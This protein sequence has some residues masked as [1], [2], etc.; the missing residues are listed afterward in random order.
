MVTRTNI[1][2]QQVLSQPFESLGHRVLYQPCCQIGPYDGSPGESIS[3]WPLKLP[4]VDWNQYSVVVIQCYDFLTI[5]QNTCIE[6]QVIEQYYKEKSCQV[7][8][9]HWERDLEKYYSG[10]L[11]LV[12][13][14]CH[15]LQ[16]ISDIVSN[17][18][19]W[20]SRLDYKKSRAWQ[21]LNGRTVSHREKTKNLLCELNNGV[22]SYGNDLALPQWS[23]KTYQGTDNFENWLRLFDV[24]HASAINVVTETIYENATGII[25]EKTLLAF[26]SLQIPIVIGYPGIV[27]HC[28][29]LGFDMFGDVV[30]I[31]YDDEPNHTRHIAAIKSNWNL[32]Q[33]L[34]FRFDLESR[35][36]QNHHWLLY[37]WPKN[38]HQHL[39]TRASEIHN[40]L[41]K[42][43]SLHTTLP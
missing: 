36:W 27:T 24:Y 39:R 31:C 14:P 40:S 42:F 19:Q 22:L 18:D 34:Q 30:N 1:D 12:Y 21:C 38:L 41:T 17:Q 43:S 32:L 9:V 23:Y 29:D 25:T 2:F 20:R 15:S 7:I 8:V 10:P 5:K 28:T 6:L 33:S 13:F 11:H 26:L 4:V 3:G 37:Q 16:L 35:L